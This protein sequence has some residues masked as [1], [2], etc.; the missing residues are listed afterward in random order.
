[1]RY[2]F[3]V[4]NGSSTNDDE[5]GTVLSG[6]EMA[7]LQAAIIAAEL[8]QDGKWYNGDVVYV[9][10][11]HGNEIGRMPVVAAIEDNSR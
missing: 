4:L 6:P 11:E 5:E 1:M 10:E 9:T 8:A 3:H 2:F 7:M